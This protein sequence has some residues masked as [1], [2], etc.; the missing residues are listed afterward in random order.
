MK[1]RSN[2]RVIVRRLGGPEGVEVVEGP[3]PEPGPGEVRIAVEAAGVSQADVT[4]RE[5]MYPEGAKLPFGLGYDLVGRVDALGPGVD[6]GRLGARVGALT[7]RGAWARYVCWRADDL[8]AVPDDLDAAVAVSLLLNYV[9]AYQLVHRAARAR[10][11]ES[12]FVTSA[13]GGV[14]TAVLQLAK[15]A[16]VDAL[17]AAS[18]RKRATVEAQG[19]RFVD[20]ARGDLREAVRAASGGG[21]HVALDGVGG[22]SSSR[23]YAALRRGGR[24]VGFGFTSKMGSPVAGRLDTFARLALHALVPDGR[25]ARFYGI[26][27]AKRA[28]PAEFAEDLARLVALAREGAIAPLIAGRLPLAQAREALRRVEAREVEGKL[29]LLPEAAA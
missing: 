4:I 27:F 19:A 26:M 1:R 8:V 17:G 15:V 7:V 6:A 23:A 13:A 3:L 9:T 21:V 22:A 29:V 12:L 2:V 18:A 10:P 25:R 5:G 14:G 16:G 24:Y 20:A 28:R 11:G